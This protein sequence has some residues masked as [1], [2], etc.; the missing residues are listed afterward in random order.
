MKQVG[1]VALG[2]TSSVGGSISGAI[3]GEI[4]IPV[5]VVGA[6]IGGLIGGFLGSKATNSMFKYIEKKHYV[7]LFNKLLRSIEE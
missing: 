2:T 7:E 1:K 4:M 3:V 5:P 6:L